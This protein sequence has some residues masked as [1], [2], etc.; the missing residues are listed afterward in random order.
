MS[1]F[2]GITRKTITQHITPE[3]LSASK[4]GDIIDTKGHEALIII[5]NIGVSGDTLSGSLFGEL[6]IEHGDAANLS[7]AANVTDNN[8]VKG[9]TVDSGG[10]YATIDDP[11]EDD[12]IVSIAYTGFKRYVRIAWDITG[13]HTNGTPVSAVAVQDRSD[14]V[15]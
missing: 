1:K 13:T 2:D 7:D 14:V 10:V 5:A 9:A 15:V 8:E 11:A 6:R 3:V 4:D 12:V